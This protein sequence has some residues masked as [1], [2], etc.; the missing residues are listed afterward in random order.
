MFLFL[1]YVLNK[2][3]FLDYILLILSCCTLYIYYLQYIQTVYQNKIRS[4][5]KY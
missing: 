5:T 3:W 1:F 2:I 4:G